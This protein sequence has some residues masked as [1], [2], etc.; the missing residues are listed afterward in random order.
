MLFFVCFR[1][2]KKNLA[3][4]AMFGTYSLI[5][6]NIRSFSPSFPD[7]YLE[8]Y[9]LDIT[10]VIILN[11]CLVFQ[12]QRERMSDRLVMGGQEAHVGFLRTVLLNQNYR[13]LHYFFKIVKRQSAG[14]CLSVRRAYNTKN[15]D[16]IPYFNTRQ[17]F[18][19][20]LFF[21]IDLN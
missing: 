10:S 20:C 13:N 14:N 9:G 18:Q 7:C 2:G 17:I 8:V 19:K 6:K 5:I 21:P 15:T 1:P 4:L 12:N 11:L 16:N 3:I